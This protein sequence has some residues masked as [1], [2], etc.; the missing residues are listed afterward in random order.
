MSWDTQ[1]AGLGYLIER[2][3]NVEN[4][5]K[6]GESTKLDMAKLLGRVPFSAG[7]KESKTEKTNLFNESLEK[8]QDSGKVKT[9]KET[10]WSG[11]G[12]GVDWDES[13]GAGRVAAS[14]VR[15]YGSP[16]SSNR[17]FSQKSVD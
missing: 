13:V 11:S 15:H 4:L 9:S 16:F 5:S 6:M 10:A 1:G 17:C 14:I 12:L 3:E 7:D 2:G 8:R